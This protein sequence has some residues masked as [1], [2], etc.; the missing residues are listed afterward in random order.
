[1]AISIF[2]KSIKRLTAWY[3]D[4]QLLDDPDDVNP[5]TKYNAEMIV[6]SVGGLII[7]LI[8]L[9]LFHEEGDIDDKN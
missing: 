8:G 7:N 1:M 4:I 9:W 2:I 6:V 5:L 3:Y